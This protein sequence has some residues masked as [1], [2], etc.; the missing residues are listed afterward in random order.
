MKR[1]PTCNRIY[2]DDGLSFCLEDGILL[3]STGGSASAPANPAGFDPNATLQ[4]DSV[5]DTNPPA[6]QI[7]SP[8]QI[9]ALP[10]TPP[11][12]NTAPPSNYTPP[13]PGGYTAQPGGY[14]APISNTP[15]VINTPPPPVINTPPPVINNNPTDTTPKKK[16]G[17]PW[18]VI[19]G[20]VIGLLV[21]GV[22]G[23]IG[24]AAYLSDDN[25]NGKSNANNANAAQT[26]ASPAPSNKEA[27]NP[28]ATAGT[29]T[30]D[31]GTPRWPTGEAAQGSMYSNGSYV[32]NFSD[33]NRFAVVYAPANDANYST[34]N[35]QSVKVEVTNLDG[36]APQIGYGLV[37]NG[38]V[39][40]GN[41]LN[42]YA[43]LIESKSGQC[44]IAQLKNSVQ[45]T[46]TPARPAPMLKKGTATNVLEVRTNGSKLEFYINGQMAAS[47]DNKATTPGRVGFYTSSGGPVAFDNLAIVRGGGGGKS[48]GSNN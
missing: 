42:G 9:P 3:V 39:V 38:S 17:L 1:C 23:I 26:T 19:G 4:F 36:N 16:S 11:A 25:K 34:D 22:I 5:R 24:L 30:D 35:V 43:F 41:L 47:T 40:N 31:F 21:I 44:L 12:V 18:L 46:V 20:A 33:P 14:T 37:V 27:A 7:L 13:Q 45:S 28:P 2:N 15:P 10:Y 6:T 32:M 48:W 29:F 8:D